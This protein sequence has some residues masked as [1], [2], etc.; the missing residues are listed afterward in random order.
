M[1]RERE[2]AKLRDFDIIVEDH[3][4]IMMGGTFEYEESSCQ[5]IGY[6]INIQFVKRLMAVFSVDRLQ[7]VNGKSCW[8]THDNSTIYKIE[9]LHKKDGEVFDVEQWAKETIKKIDA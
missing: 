1:K 2:L 7:R 8:V 5:G 4:W 9:P 6:G 3:G